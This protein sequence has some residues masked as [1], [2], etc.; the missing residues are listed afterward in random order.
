MFINIDLIFLNFL[1][2]F[3]TNFV[4]FKEECHDDYASDHKVYGNNWYNYYQWKYCDM[5]CRQ[6][7]QAGFCRYP[8]TSLYCSKI[9]NLL[10]QDT[11]KHSCE[12]CRKFSLFYY[13]PVYY[14]LRSIS[15]WG[16]FC[17]CKF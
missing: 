17:T 4:D 3:V 1:Y 6:L 16:L 11:C 14:Y 15:F 2:I 8:W 10:I 7:A 9:P 12:R 5:S 13:F